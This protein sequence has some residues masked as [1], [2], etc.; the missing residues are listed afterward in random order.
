MISIVIPTYNR[1]S[2]LKTCIESI[3]PQYY[4]GLEI[5]IID[6]H[7]TDSTQHYLEELK[8]YQFIKIVTNSVNRG[9]NYSRNRGIEKVTKKFILFLDSDDELTEGSLDKI[10]NKV[11]ENSEIKHFLFIV[12]DRV[13][14]FKHLAE[15]RVVQYGDWVSGNIF[16]DFTHVVYADVMKKFLFFEQ[17]RMYEYLNWLRIKKETS[18][19][20]LVPLVTTQRERDRSDSLTASGKLKNVSVI[21]SRFESEKLYYSLYHKDL[22]RYNPKSL[23]YKLIETILLGVACDQKRECRSLIHY[24]SKLHIKILGSLVMLLP[25]SFLKYGIIKYSSLKR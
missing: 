8:Q 18:P 6:D 7:S 12:S 11:E 3:L 17:F 13:D 5:I 22:S 24:A 15:T 14:D 2:S 21:K 4:D 10:R 9:V 23:T 16:G 1:V 25:S 20:L 19:Q